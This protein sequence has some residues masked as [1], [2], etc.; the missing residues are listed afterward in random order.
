[1]V[2]GAFVPGNGSSIELPFPETFV[3]GDESSTEL[4]TPATLD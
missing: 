1:M 2:A 3:P 4:S